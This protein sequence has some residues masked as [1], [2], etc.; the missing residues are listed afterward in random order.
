[1]SL[2]IHI[3]EVCLAT[4]CVTLG[5]QVTRQ[6][7]IEL[8]RKSTLSSTQNAD[9]VTVSS[10]TPKQVESETISVKEPLL[11]PQQPTLVKQPSV[12]NAQPVNKVRVIA[13]KPEATQQSSSEQEVGSATQIL[14][15]YIGAFFDVPAKPEVEIKAFRSVDEQE[16]ES[17]YRSDA[18]ND[19]VSAIA[20]AIDLSLY[21][22]SNVDASDKIPVLNSPIPEALITER[23]LEQ[24]K[25]LDEEVIVVEEQQEVVARDSV[26]SDKVVL[27]MLGEAKLVGSS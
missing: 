27:A 15:D 17:Y 24:V 22:A 4:L 9:A 2:I 26:M 7:K 10:V 18:G 23:F 12:A 6:Y 1:M 5:W 11:E 3:L 21:K 14:G 16:V 13:K 20:P 8:N 25:E 19:H